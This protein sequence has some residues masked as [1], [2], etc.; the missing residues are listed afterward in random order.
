MQTAGRLEEGIED[1]LNCD[2]SSRLE[3]PGRV[4]GRCIAMTHAR[5]LDSKAWGLYNTFVVGPDDAAW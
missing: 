5:M 2:A 4:A 1:W 3:H